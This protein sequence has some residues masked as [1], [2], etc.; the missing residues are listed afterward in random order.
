M[1]DLHEDDTTEMKPVRWRY[2]PTIPYTFDLLVFGRILL[3]RIN[4]VS[5]SQRN[6]VPV[7]KVLVSG[8]VGPSGDVG[9]AR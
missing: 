5:D 7:N 9:A 1:K 8:G 2:S 3:K 4:I 6:N